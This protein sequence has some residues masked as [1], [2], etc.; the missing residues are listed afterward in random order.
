MQILAVIN[1]PCNHPL[2]NLQV[3]RMVGLMF[4]EIMRIL[5][6]IDSLHYLKSV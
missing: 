3:Q 6:H 2:L 5:N 4:T 1:M